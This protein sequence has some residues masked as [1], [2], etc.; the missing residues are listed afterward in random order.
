MDKH[1]NI[2]NSVIIFIGLV[3]LGFSIIFAT[4]ALKPKEKAEARYE[5]V[6]LNEVNFAIIDKQTNKIYYK[7]IAPNAGPNSWEEMELPS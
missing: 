5:I 7:Y 1:S 3:F 6:Q 2:I 4:N